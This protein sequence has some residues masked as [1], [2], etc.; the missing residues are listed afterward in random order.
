[1]CMIKPYMY[2]RITVCMTNTYTQDNQPS[3]NM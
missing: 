1:M 2:K 3:I